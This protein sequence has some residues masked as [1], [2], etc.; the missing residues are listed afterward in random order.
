[1]SVR[2]KTWG[3]VKTGPGGIR[4]V[5]FLVQG[6]QLIHGPAQPAVRSVNTL[7]GIVRLADHGFLQADEYRCLSSGYAFLRTIEH[8]LQL[9]HNKRLHTLPSDARELACLVRR[10]DFPDADEFLHHY[11]RHSREIRSVFDRHFR[12]KTDAAGKQGKLDTEPRRV[13]TR[14]RGGDIRAGLRRVAATAAC[15]TAGSTERRTSGLHGGSAAR[16]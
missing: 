6:L 1:M 7:D 11:E 12:A 5:E 10:L 3:N 16:R 2:P 14:H 8:A 15:P 13:S 9:T 4:D